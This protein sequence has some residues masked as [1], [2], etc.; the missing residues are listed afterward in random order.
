MNATKQK[1]RKLLLHNILF[2]LMTTAVWADISGTIF[3]DFNLNGTQDTLEPGISG[4]TVTAYDDNGAVGLSQTTDADGHYTLVTGA[5]KFRVEVTNVPSYLKAGTAISGSTAALVSIVDNGDTHHVGLH[6]TG[7]Y[8]QANPDIIM[9]RFTKDDSSS[10]VNRHVNTILQFPYTANGEDAPTNISEYSDVGAVYG[11]AHLRK[12]NVTYTSTYLKRHADIG[13]SGIGAIYKIDH[14][15]GNAV[16]TFATLPGTDPRNAGAGYDWGH[17]TV[18][19]TN[20]G[21]TGIGDIELSDDESQLFAVNMDDK[22]L[23]VY[24]VDANGN[25]GA[26]TSYTIPNPCTN[27]IDFRPMGLGFHD[28]ILYVGTTCTAEST[29]DANNA[30]HSTNGPRKGDKSQLSAHI[31]SFVPAITTF[32]ATPVLDIDLTYDRGCIY[33]ADISNAEPNTDC[34]YTDHDGI[35]QPYRANWNPWQMDYD[36][37]F[38]DKAPGDIGNQDGW[39]EYM[40]PLLSDIEFDNDGSMI[41]AI[42]DV[43]GDRTGNDNHSPNP[44]D[45]DTHNGNGEG[46]ILRACGNPQAGWTLES[47]GQ[48]GGITTGGANTHEGPGGGE[49]YWYD[50]GPGGNGHSTIGYAG[51][52]G[53]SDTIMGGLLHVPGHNEIVTGVMDV[54]RFL[55]NGLLWLRN[56][57]GEIATDGNGDPKRLLVSSTNKNQ[58]FGKASGMGD[59]EALC[60]AAPIEIG[61]YVWEDTDGDGIQDPDEAVLAGVTVNL[62]EGATLVGTAIT[63]ANGEYYFGGSANANMVGGNPLKPLTA[64]QL[65]IDLD[66]ANLGARVPTQKDVNANADDIHDSDGDNGVLN[67]GFSSIAYTTGTAGANDHTLDFGFY[68]PAVSIG[69]IVWN[70]ANNNGV[71]DAGESGING[72]TVELLDSAGNVVDTQTTDNTG[73]YYFDNL[74]EGDYRVRVT[75]PA[76]M[77]KS[78]N[79]T[80][81]D[82]NDAANDSNIATSA[83]NVHTSGLFTLSNDGEPD[84]VNSNIAGSDDA[85]NADDNNGN[86]T[87]DFGFYTP[88]VSIGSIVWN[89]ANNNGVQDAGESGINGATVE[90]L[91]SAGNVVD[92]QTTDNTGLYYFDNLPEG[93][94]RVRVTPPAGMVKSTNQTTADNNDAANDSNIATS[95]GNVHTSGLFTLSNDGEPDGVNSNIAGSDDADNADDNNGN[96]TVDFGFYTPAVSIG[97]IVWNDAN[98]NG[99]QDAGESGINGAT[100][101]LL[102]SAGNVVDTQTHR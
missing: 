56:D 43:N 3:R 98:N 26:N 18:G 20:V 74:P 48:C 93:D 86:M 10:G 75:P 45:N 102:D 95:A 76:G 12:A 51:T 1:M 52:A 16:S 11:V 81:A 71:Q 69:S 64:Y 33:N 38:N 54:H 99:V 24:D 37:V 79:Q 84:G 49:Y 4:L 94:Y 41:I 25:A 80:T 66:D 7:Q 19:Y 57:N 36:I 27:A 92:T 97:S 67:P 61:N 60:D 32:S 91:D 17:D 2:V 31:Y 44:A 40:Q 96:M 21:K 35:S 83:G 100:V 5:G 28:G 42:R 87:V 68:T 82:N 30:D 23:Y 14:A 90:L 85:D 13:P 65:R 72:A 88:A 22:K 70:D 9:T 29:V 8:C 46:D 58:F 34:T 63:G 73:L 47:N 89:D 6:N 62:Y 101:E 50:N 78:T 53:H 77:V 15:N 59:I 55:D 39:I